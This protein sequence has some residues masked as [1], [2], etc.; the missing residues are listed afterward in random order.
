MSKIEIMDFSEN[1]VERTADEALKMNSSLSKV[2]I[3]F[4]SKRF[5][6]F[7]KEEFKHRIRET[8]ILP[9]MGTIDEFV[10]ELYLQSSPGFSLSDDI[11]SSY[12]LYRIVKDIFMGKKLYAGEQDSSSFLSFYPWAQKIISGIEEILIEAEKILEQTAV[13][14]KFS[15][16]GEYNEVYKDFITKLPEITDSYSKIHEDNKFFTRGM[17]YRRIKSED[18]EGVLPEPGYDSYIFAGFYALNPCEKVLIRHILKNCN[19]SLFLVRAQKEDKNPSLSPFRTAFETVKEIGGKPPKSP[20]ISD[21]DLSCKIQIYPCSN[22]E[23]EMIQICDSLSEYLR[24]NKGA[25]LTKIGILLPDPSSLMSFVSNVI[26][27]F[28]KE[29][30]KFNITLSYPFQRTSLFQ[31]ID[32]ILEISKNFNNGRVPARLYLQLIKHPYLKLSG[33]SQN[34]TDLRKE[35]HRIETLIIEKNILYLQIDGKGGFENKSLSEEFSEALK[36]IDLNFL[37]SGEENLK[38]LCN[39]ISKCL[40]LISGG[41][42]NYLFFRDFINSAKEALAELEEFSEKNP[43]AGEGQNDRGKENFI[44]QKM[45]LVPVRFVG[46][47]LE[48]IQVMGALEFRNLNFEAVFIADCVEGIMPDVSK[49][50]PLLPG[51]IK[52]LFSMRQYA[53]WENVYAYNFFSILSSAKSVKIFYPEKIGGRIVKRSRFIESLVHKYPEK[54]DLIAT[55]NLNFSLRKSEKSLSIEKT[56]KIKEII[57]NKNLS[58]TSFEDYL[59]CPMKFYYKK[60]LGMEEKASLEET[61]DAASVGSVVHESL[62]S[63]YRE[64]SGKIGEILEKISKERGIVSDEGTGKIKFWG[65]K[66]MLENFVKWDET[67]MKDKGTEIIAMEKEISKSFEIGEYTVKFRGIIDRI[68]RIGEETFICD[69]KTKKEQKLFENKNENFMEMKV[70][71]LPELGED[72]YRNEFPKLLKNCGC[73]Q[74][75]LYIKMWMEENGGEIRNTNAKYY[76]LRKTGK[77][78]E[79][80]VF[81][82]ENREAFWDKFQNIFQIVMRDLLYNP[83]FNALPSEISCKYCPFKNLCGI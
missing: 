29:S 60:V 70:P 78:T 66:R 76:L 15:S 42:K 62:Y 18:K 79:K 57:T 56:D 13:Y 75:L 80:I 69:Y 33:G 54:N 28:E 5:G 82:G 27:R 10:T 83:R 64:K 14:E 40:D 55:K 19:D 24:V 2:R 53:E 74:V 38:E 22:P 23:H 11:Q 45:S 46:N 49:Y 77:E 51:D 32:I 8:A 81:T 59:Y 36:N 41:G 7:L 68:E 35:M 34:N 39:R 30:V 61:P 26:S 67:N 48:G 25:D 47:P 72:D 71:E 20:K 52:E 31:L 58:P 6:F 12:F 65:V 16:L 1:L 17:A 37:P 50:D 43:E 63:Y 21:V 44:G 3:V 4:P 73:Y 9:A